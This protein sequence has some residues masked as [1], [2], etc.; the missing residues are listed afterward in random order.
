MSDENVTTQADIPPAPAM[1]SAPAP[2][3]P[4]RGRPKKTT[5]EKVYVR[6]VKPYGMFCHT[7]DRYIRPIDPTPVDLDN[8]IKAQLKAGTLELVER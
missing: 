1:E 3:K 6:T 7:Q 4:K 5:V 2:E 8:W